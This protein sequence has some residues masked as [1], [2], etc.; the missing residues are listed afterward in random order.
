MTKNMFQA[1]ALKQEEDK[2]VFDKKKP[3]AHVR[4][5]RQ[6]RR[7]VLFIDKLADR[8]I[9]IGGILVIIVVLGILV[10]L[11]QQTIPLFRSA[12]VTNVFEYQTN[13]MQDKI[14]GLGID[15]Y[16]TVFYS[17]LPDGTINVFHVRTGIKLQE[18]KI[19]FLGKTPTS[20]ATTIDQQ[21]MVFAFD[22][23][24]I[25]PVAIEFPSEILS[26]DELPNGLKKLD[27]RDKTDN[28]RVYSQIPDESFREISVRFKADAPIKVNSNNRSIILVDIKSTNED[29]Q[30]R[31][32]IVTMDED[33][34]MA[35]NTAR[36]STNLLTGQEKA[37]FV[38]TKLPK[39]DNPAD[40]RTLLMT[41]RADMVLAF[42]KTGHV[43]RYNL[44]DFDKPVLVEISGLLPKGRMLTTAGF[45]SGEQSLVVAGNDGSFNIFFMINDSTRGTL[46]KKAIVKARS[47][48]TDGSNAI[49]LKPSGRSKCMAVAFDD[50][51]L[52]VWHGTS[53]KTIL[54][55]NGNKASAISGISLSPRLDGLLAIDN[56]G[57]VRFWEFY[58]PHPETTFQT[59]FRKVWYEGYTEPTY[60]WQSSAGTDDY[61]SKF[62]L[63]P[64]IFGSIKGA[65]YSLLFAVP[66]AILGAIYTSEFA[67]I[68][69]KRFIKPI[70]EMMASLPSVVLG[71]VAALVLAPVVQTWISAVL[72]LFL[73][74]P[75]SLL[76]GSI[77]WRLLPQNIVV[78]Q[79]SAGKLFTVLGVILVALFFTFNISLSFE[80]FFFNGDFKAWLNKDFGTAESF[81]FLLFLPICFLI[82][83]YIFSKHLT[84]KDFLK[85]KAI[86][87]Q[88]ATVIEASKWFV[89]AILAII[90]SYTLAKVFGIFGVDPR[91]EFVDTYAQRNTLV[92]GFAMGFAVIPIIYTIAED[93]LSAV[94]EH[95]RAASLGCAATTWQTTIY[96]VLP[97]AMSGIFSAIMVGMGRAVGETMI[98]VMAAGNTP[99]MDWNIFNGL[100]ALSATIAVELPE[101]VK[102]GTLYRIL[103]L[104]GLVLFMLTFI[105]NTGAEIIRLR[106]R[107]RA[108]QI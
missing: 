82:F 72:L 87:R 61:E 13:G 55:I 92:V 103:F 59:L 40:F 57:K 28:Q 37:T 64:L 101:A 54:N 27:K 67:P 81:H 80:A 63:I 66:I 65:F 58:A 19:D 7:S 90:S 46:D 95:L 77:F 91:G 33:G 99:L 20:F 52:T 104:S 22:D 48:D 102:G 70:M 51:K 3:D 79:Q 96:I 42:S 74:V 106:F 43:Y 41:D 5:G 10:F 26:K 15:E 14:V 39:V 38:T 24:T 56:T 25:I 98:V 31:Q 78:R 11:V 35:L 97:T 16:N 88:T 21:R 29:G 49:Y 105:I 4:S 34:Q 69:Q 86:N 45:L 89:S 23:G 71:F 6:V 1:N 75:L 8:I 107:K 68:G 18:Q 44:R 9:T 93:A 53:Q 17:V 94:P 100:R 84:F 50:G 2:R 108:M 62:S 60:T 83:A 36:Y 85:D 32:S 73:I 30:K 12:V 76:I 47:F